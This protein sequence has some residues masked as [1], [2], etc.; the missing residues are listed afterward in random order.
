MVGES[1]A[2]QP[3]AA[4]KQSTIMR[5]KTE[6]AS[7]TKAGSDGDKSEGEDPDD[8]L[9]A[10]YNRMNGLHERL[11]LDLHNKKLERMGLRHE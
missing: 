7:R 9:C 3:Q 2:S 8:L 1:Q 11:N 10:Y 4:R 5:E 6:T